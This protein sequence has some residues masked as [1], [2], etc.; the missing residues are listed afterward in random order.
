MKYNHTEDQIKI[1]IK[2]LP[3]LDTEELA[4]QYKCALTQQR[5]DSSGSKLYK[6][7]LDAIEKEL[8]KRRKVTDDEQP[9]VPSEPDLPS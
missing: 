9:E 8:R 3:E 4:H 1:A 5:S 6:P 2:K 7:F